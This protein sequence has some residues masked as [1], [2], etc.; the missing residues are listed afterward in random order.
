MVGRECTS[1]LMGVEIQVYFRVIA[2]EVDLANFVKS[3]LG[4]IIKISKTNLVLETHVC[5][6]RAIV[7]ER[8]NSKKEIL[9][10][11]SVFSQQH[12]LLC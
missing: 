3:L 12:S 11:V 10:T 6:S 7:L 8:E 1:M 9:L 5:N 2:R 4:I